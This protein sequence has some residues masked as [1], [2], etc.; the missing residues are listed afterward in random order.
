MVSAV[1]FELAGEGL[2]EAGLGPV[3]AGMAIGAL[4]FYALAGAWDRFSQRRALGGAVVGGTGGALPL[5]AILDSIPEMLVLGIQLSHGQGL[6]LPLIL[7]IFVSNLPEA[8]GSAAELRKQGG[9]RRRIAVLWGAVAVGLAAVTPIGAAVADRLGPGPT[10]AFNGFAAGALLVMLVDAMAPEARGK[11]DGV[12]GLATTL[13][14]TTS[15]VLNSISNQQRR[16]DPKAS[17]IPSP[18]GRWHPLQA[19]AR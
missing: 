17:S 9:D 3:A 10:A 6:S 11:A 4:T 12:S 14:L 1:S 15:V 8:M 7:A 13:G 19:G 2:R 18:V 16:K 5:G